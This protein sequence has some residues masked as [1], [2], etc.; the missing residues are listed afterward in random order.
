MM[1]LTNDEGITP[2]SRDF[3][4]AV[5]VSDLMELEAISRVTGDDP[6]G[7]AA[8]AEFGRDLPAASIVSGRQ[9][10]G[11]FPID[12]SHLRLWYDSVCSFEL[13]PELILHWPEDIPKPSWLTTADKAAVF[14]MCLEKLDFR[15]AWL[16][17]NSHGWRVGEAR[18]AL[19]DLAKVVADPLFSTMTE[20]WCSTCK[21]E[22][23]SY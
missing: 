16:A 21:G 11:D 19:V 1:S 22:N 20:A 18:S 13:A 2:S 9:Y 8:I 5:G 14:R 4:S 12:A 17:L 3:A 15:G 7:F 10:H 6:K 23:E